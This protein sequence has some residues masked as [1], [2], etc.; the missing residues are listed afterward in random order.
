MANK[1][2]K[3][4]P[5]CVID[6]L[7]YDPSTGLLTW[8]LSRGSAAKGSIAGCFNGRYCVLKINRILYYV[9]RVAWFIHFKTQPVGLLDHIDGNTQ[10]NRI[11]NLRIAN[12]F[13]NQQ[14]VSVKCDSRSFMK[15]VGITRFGTYRV[16]VSVAGKR[17]PVG[18]FDSVHEAREAAIVFRNK[19]HGEF[20]NHG[21]KE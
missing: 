7:A 19:N 14:N 16:R 3:V 2:C 4:I 13:Q 12:D 10:N 9:H 1:H 15:N 17:I 11:D 5:D 6:M 21:T 18:I 20:A 8:N